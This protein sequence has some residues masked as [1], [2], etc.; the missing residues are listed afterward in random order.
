MVGHQSLWPVFLHYTQN[1]PHGQE[2]SP[3]SENN[4]Y[5]KESLEG[6]HSHL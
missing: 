5:G 2:M 6:C 4:N 3:L 1:E